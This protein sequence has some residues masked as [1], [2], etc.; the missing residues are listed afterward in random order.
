MRVDRRLDSLAFLT[1][2]ALVGTGLL[3]LC[4]CGGVSSD[5]ASGSQITDPNANGAGNGSA[6]TGAN[7]TAGTGSGMGTGTP[8]VVVGGFVGGPPP[9]TSM[10][11][12]CIQE[13]VMINT[14]TPSVEL[15]V[16]RSQSMEAMFG[17]ADRWNTIR[18]VLVNPTTG[19]VKEMEARVRFGLTLYTSFQAGGGG[20]AGGAPAGGCPDLI[21]VPISLNNFAMIQP[22]FMANEVGDNTP[23]AEGVTAVT[24]KLEMYQEVGP[25][26][27][28]L[29]TDGDPDSCADPD[30][31][32][33][34][35]PRAASE[36]AVQAAF[37]KGILTYV[38]AVGE[39]ITD[40]QHMQDL[41][42]IGAG[43]DPAASY[44]QASNTMALT[45]AFNT[46][47]RGVISCDF[48]L[49]GTVADTAAP[50]G[51]VKID[52]TELVYG[53]PNGWVLVNGDTVRLQGEACNT[54]KIEVSFVDITFPCGTVMIR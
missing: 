16:D 2:S 24:T 48:T 26:V 11:N 20:G 34:E 28:V 52:G 42:V 5:S 10:G 44:F 15:L 27:I 21:Q 14:L 32:G 43:G 51:S 4:S 49:N 47:L 25:K 36:A 1:R 22:I 31:N 3:F 33:T 6:G 41:A 50:S 46:I 23:T 39:D 54:L 7:G 45:E 35:P 29:A 30:S 40:L 37:D 19:F 13:G 18:D 38:I 12:T 8:D 9:V 53:D 17:A